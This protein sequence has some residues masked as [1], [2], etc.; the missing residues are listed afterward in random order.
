MKV[1]NL[2]AGLGGNRKLWPSDVEVWAVEI[3]PLIAAEYAKKFPNDKVIVG[4]AHKFLLENFK[5]FDFIWSSPPCPTHSDIRRLGVDIGQVEPVYPDM[6]LYEEIIFLTHFYNGKWVVENVVP[7]YEP[8]IKPVIRGRHC[9]W[10]NFI[11]PQ[12]RGERSVVIDQVSSND[13]VFGFNISDSN[14]ENKRKVLRNCVDPVLGL[15]VFN[16]AFRIK[17]CLL[18]VVL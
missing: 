18:E 14:I 3:D 4:D 11:I 7:Y 5:H 6:I 8:L 2:Y 12:F 16:S 1:L 9:F 17:Q 15:H 13:T 10:S